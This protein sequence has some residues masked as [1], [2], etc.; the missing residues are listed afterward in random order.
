MTRTFWSPLALIAL[1]IGLAPIWGCSDDDTPTDPGGGDPG[2][3]GVGTITG[4]VYRT[5]GFPEDTV[6]V[7]AGGITT[8]TNEEGY[9]V[10]SRVPEGEVVVRFS[11]SGGATTYRVVSVAEG[12]LIHLPDVVLAN[13]QTTLIDGETGGL[14]SY[15]GTGSVEFAPGSFVGASG[16]PFSGMVWVYLLVMQPQHGDFYG[17]FPGA[18]DGV[19]ADE[20]E[21]PFESFGFLTVELRGSGGQDVELAPG[22]TATLRLNLVG[23]WADRA[24]A[25]IPM[26]SFDATTGR[27][28]EEGTATL[29]DNVYTA[30]VTHLDTWNWDLPM[31]DICS[32]SGFVVND[33]EQPVVGARVFSRGVDHRF[34]DETRTNADGRYTVRAVKN[35]L[36]DVWAMSGS[37]V[38][39][40]LR[41]SVGDECPEAAAEPLVVTVPAYSI[42]LTWGEEP[43]DLDSH[44]LIPMTWNDEYTHY[45]IAY[46]SKGTLGDYPYAMLDTDDTSS[47]G[48][49]IITGTRVF[50]GRFQYWVHDFT[51][52]DSAVLAASGATV[53]LELAGSLYL[54]EVA[55][56]PLEGGDSEGWWHVCDI[57]VE[58]GFIDVQ[59]VMRFEPEFSYDGVYDQELKSVTMKPAPAR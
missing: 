26:W 22:A 27:W 1:L 20:T 35:G 54:F 10:L 46:Y 6:A 9:F 18:Y 24:P 45:H 28:R 15:P 51:S 42:A 32:I 48:P 13:M 34:M 12:S 21:V 53:Q 43:E 5:G 52:D 55:D 16:Q 41:V 17:A 58:N 38:G 39:E 14:A 47:F 4:V 33:S 57:L 49:E 50:S 19:R 2:I 30:L 37:L 31:D 7:T 25:S 11:A 40:S 36:T 56:V 23:D 59:P 44:L 3:E 8:T 29:A